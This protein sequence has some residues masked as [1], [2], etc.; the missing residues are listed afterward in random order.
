MKHRKRS[1]ANEGER[2]IGHAGPTHPRACQPRVCLHSMKCVYILSFA[3][4]GQGDS[5]VI[6]R[7]RMGPNRVGTTRQG[8]RS[9]ANGSQQSL[10]CRSRSLDRS[11]GL[12]VARF[13]GGVRSMAHG[14]Y[15]LLALASQR[16]VGTRGTRGIQRDGD[17]TRAD[18]LDHRSSPPAFGRGSKKSGPQALGRSRGGLT[19][20]LH[21][22]VDEA[23]RPL[24]MIVTE[25][26]FRTFPAP[27]N[28]SSICA[29]AR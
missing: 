18:R 20:K 3:R 4:A 15:A 8:R 12:P 14:V 29:R 25:G 17:Q 23:G 10:V 2:I 6:E 24:R 16:C 1:G 27:T 26:R 19:T 22:A 11:D 7:R 21:L 5:N 13:A 9:G 28:W